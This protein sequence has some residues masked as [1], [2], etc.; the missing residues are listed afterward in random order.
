MN[1]LRLWGPSA[2]LAVATISL[3]VALNRRSDMETQTVDCEDSPTEPAT[4]DD[5]QVSLFDR[6]TWG[7]GQEPV[8]YG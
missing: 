7:S 4:S 1:Q 8:I 5:A 3:F 6:L 2:A